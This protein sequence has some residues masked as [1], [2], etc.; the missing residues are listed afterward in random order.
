M[1]TTA[2]AL[3]LTG[4][5]AGMGTSRQEDKKA[6]DPQSVKERIEKQ[7][8]SEEN[9]YPHDPDIEALVNYAHYAPAEF[10]ADALLRIVESGKL[11]DQMWKRELAGE[12]FQLASQA[13][14]P[15]KRSSIPGALVDT[16]SG[17]LSR[18]F[19]LGLDGLSLRCRAIKAMVPIDKHKAR[20][21]FQA[22]PMPKLE[23]LT[24][25]DVLVYDLSA[26]YDTLGIIAQNTFTAKEM[27]SNEY[28]FF[29]KSYI[30]AAS[31][32]AQVGPLAK[33]ILALRISP[34]QLAILVHAFSLTLTH[35]VGDNKSFSQ[36]TTDYSIIPEITSLVTLCKQLDIPR[37]ELVDAFREYLVNNLHADRCAVAKAGGEQSSEEPSYVGYFNTNL[38]LANLP[39]RKEVLPI[40]IEEIKPTRIKDSAKVYPFW[41][42]PKSKGLLFRFKNLRFASDE[43]RFGTNQKNE[44]EWQWQ[45]TQFLNDLADWHPEDEASEEDYFH[46]KSV[47]F[48]ALL[49]ELPTGG[50]QSKVLSDYVIFLSDSRMQQNSPIEWY[51]HAQYL[52]DKMHSS[53]DGERSEVREGLNRSHNTTFYLYA[54]MERLLPSAKQPQQ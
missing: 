39:S 52:I 41:Q 18:A 42:S 36:A 28:T 17:Y 48:R 51:L 24:C 25:E 21:L 8:T 40:T 45:L 35:I 43:K 49:E 19:R 38:R 30:E 4:I 1:K 53:Q 29:I 6:K 50:V 34:S 44:P 14:Q 20:E 46:Q 10:G 27:R 13:K 2:W 47:L 37:D 9:K 12:A 11:A 16:R 3:I 32:P 7:R 31:S 33:V 54:E 22:I 15:V 23:P 5:I 26:F